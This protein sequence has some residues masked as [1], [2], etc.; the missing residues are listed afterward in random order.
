MDVLQLAKE[1]ISIQ[2]HLEHPAFER[3]IAVKVADVL[4]S[5]GIDCDITEIE[6]NRLNVKGILK[7]IGG[8]KTLIFNTHLDTIP[9]YG[10]DD[11]YTP[12]ESD[13]RLYGRGACDVRGAL[14]CLCCTMAE[15][16]NNGALKG[17]V[18]FLA[19]CDE[20]S[21]SLGA[22]AA[23]P[24]I[25]ADAAVICEPTGLLVGI[26][27]KGVEWFEA[28]FSGVA[29]HGGN[30]DNGH[31]AIYDAARFVNDLEKFDK[32]VLNQRVHPLIGRSTL[33]VGTIQGGSK[34]TVVPSA[35][36]VGFERRWLPT[37]ER[38]AV[39][40][41]LRVIAGQ[42][43]AV[44][45]ECVLGGSEKPFPPMEIDAGHTL[46]QSAL[47]ARRQILQ[48][49]DAPIGVPFWTEA[50]LFGH[51]AGIP[52]VV[53]GPGYAAQAH[54]EEEYVD[55]Q[56]LYEASKIY[57]LLATKFCNMEE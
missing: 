44:H 15:L 53:I 25:K 7:G 54:S 16:K 49:N 3:D 41:E 23:L 57:A 32:T 31:N 45:L 5:S 27:H 8:G 22:R 18:I 6:P 50:S 10:M 47:F 38:A 24:D 40:E 28:G 29:A 43:S 37:E 48:S 2:G 51:L 11:A 21:G 33:N 46:V 36:S 35:C 13:G 12:R 52:A 1:F 26:A 14:A 9:A 17:D 55:I 42:S 34:C 39:V 56:Q 19:T 20:E 30:P 4:R